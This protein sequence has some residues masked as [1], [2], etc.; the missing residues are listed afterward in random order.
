MVKKRAGHDF[1]FVID[2][3]SVKIFFQSVINFLLL[4]WKKHLCCQVLIRGVSC[5][6]SHSTAT[7]EGLLNSECSYSYSRMCSYKADE[8]LPREHL[9]NSC[10]W[11]WM[12]MKALFLLFLWIFTLRPDYVFCLHCVDSYIPAEGNH[13][14]LC[15]HCKLYA[16]CLFLKTLRIAQLE[17]LGFYCFVTGTKRMW[18]RT[19]IAW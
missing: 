13:C 1:F 18:N 16:S 12:I 11:L 19:L 4:L 2:S 17:R 8:R 6:S 7:H 3:S 15:A 9:T 14:K 10:L 5:L